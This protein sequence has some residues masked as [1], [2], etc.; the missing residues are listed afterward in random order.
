MLIVDTHPHVMVKPSERYPFAP[1]GGQQSGWSRDV[2][3]DGDSFAEMM[4]VAGVGKAA[5]VQTSTVYGFDNRFLADTVAAR[6]ETFA[7]VCSIDALAGDAAERLSYWITERGLSGV[8]LFSAAAAMGVLFE[9]DDP[10][11]DGFWRCACELGIPV[12]LQIRYPGLAAVRRVLARYEGLR[13]VLDHI[14]GAPVTGGPSYDGAA[15][16]VAMADFGRVYVKFANH[17]LDAADAAEGSTAAGFLGHLVQAF[18]ADHLLWGSNFPNTFGKSPATLET[19]TS[20]VS[21]VVTVT[22]E[23][24]SDVA[25]QLLGETAQRV[26]PGLAP[27]VL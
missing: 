12:D 4:R 8:R 9:V 11:L 23:L 5:L 21:R 22:S 14:G 13:V 1:V 25:A 19:Y 6:P 3:L 18:G 26:Y 10:R 7:G 16:L 15:D 2:E 24:G 27:R 20:M 17:N